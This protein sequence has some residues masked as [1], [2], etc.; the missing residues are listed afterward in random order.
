MGPALDFQEYTED[1][2]RLT[3]SGRLGTRLT[4]RTLIYGAMVLVDHRAM[5]LSA[6]AAQRATETVLAF[7]GD[8]LG[9]R[10]VTI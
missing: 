2:D 10:V 3:R 5:Q 8:V 6:S 9:L 7:V 4:A 1:L